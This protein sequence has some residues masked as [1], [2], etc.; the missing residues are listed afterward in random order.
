MFTCLKM[1]D[2]L[3]GV[4]DVRGSL[5]D[6]PLFF[7]QKTQLVEREGNQVVIVSDTALTGGTQRTGGTL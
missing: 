1:T 3:L 2:N 5:D 7:V 4:F 6:V